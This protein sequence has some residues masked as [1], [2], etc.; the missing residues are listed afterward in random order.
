MQTGNYA[1]NWFQGIEA[2]LALAYRAEVFKTGIVEQ[3]VCERN[4]FLEGRWTAA[5]PGQQQIAAGKKDIICCIPCHTAKVANIPVRINR[6]KGSWDGCQSAK[7]EVGKPEGE[8][9]RPASLRG[10]G[11]E[12]QGSGGLQYFSLHAYS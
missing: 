4:K 10:S 1:G 6:S 8:L 12:V 7:A 11:F 3:S 2:C 9:S 5:I